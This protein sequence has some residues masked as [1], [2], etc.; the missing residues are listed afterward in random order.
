[1]RTFLTR[2]DLATSLPS[3]TGLDEATLKLVAERANELK[4]WLTD[5]GYTELHCEIPVL[6]RS[7]EGAEI[8]GTIDLLAVGPQGCLLI[9]HKT[10]GAGVGF[11]PYWPQLF[12]YSTLVD[13]VLR[14]HRMR[15]VGLHWMDHGRMDLVEL[16]ATVGVE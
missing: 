8:P 13:S 5:Q 15:G 11:G 4:A 6:E 16:P 10:G 3:A 1:M 7:A 14:G 2:P 9:D 12:A